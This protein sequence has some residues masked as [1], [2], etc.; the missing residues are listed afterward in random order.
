MEAGPLLVHGFA[1]G[2]IVESLRRLLGERARKLISAQSSDGL[3]ALATRLDEPDVARAFEDSETVTA[4]ALDHAHVLARIASVHD[5]VPL[6]LGTLVSGR[7]ALLD[8]CETQ[9]A[10]MREALEAV[11]GHV[12]FGV[13]LIASPEVRPKATERPTDGRSYLRARS[14]ERGADARFGEAQR[15]Y[16]ATLAERLMALACVKSLDIGSASAGKGR[17]LDAACLVERRGKDAFAEFVA[18]E[19]LTARELSL[20]LQVTGPWPAYSFVAA[21]TARVN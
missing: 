16:Q 19:V 21:P 11:S 5:I 8:L 4:L 7:G 15:E 13:R 6:R 10:P 1:K 20:S 9:A 12:E 14:R 2:E 17:A 3:V 18:R